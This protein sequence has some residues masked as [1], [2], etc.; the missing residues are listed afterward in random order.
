MFLAESMITMLSAGLMGTIIGST[1]AYLLDAQTAILT[2]V[3]QIFVPPWNTI[4]I[5]FFAS[6]GLGTLGMYGVLRGI[7]KQSIM[8]IFRKTF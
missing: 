5:V 1:V 6:V 2:E 8:D 7:M 3:P 4:F